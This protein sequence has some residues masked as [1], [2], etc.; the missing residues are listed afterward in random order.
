MQDSGDDGSG[1]VD[2]VRHRIGGAGR[3]HAQRANAERLCFLRSS[4][5]V[6]Q[7]GRS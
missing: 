3:V 2:A 5:Y 1:A 7:V 4:D 6:Q